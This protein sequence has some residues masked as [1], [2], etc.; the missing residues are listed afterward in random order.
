MRK[1]LPL[2]IRKYAKEHGGWI[3]KNDLSRLEFKTPKGGIYG[4][5]LISRKARLLEESSILAVKYED[6]CALYKYI[7]DYLRDLYIT[8]SSR[9]NPST[10][11]KD[12]MEVR[13]RMSLYSPRHDS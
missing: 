8:S 2:L 10:L 7:P 3:H 6:G 12:E 13:R 11:W 1:G 9:S 4:A 5:E